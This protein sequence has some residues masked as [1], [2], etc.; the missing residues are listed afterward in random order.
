MTTITESEI[1]E[2][3]RAALSKVD[4]TPEGFFTTVELAAATGKCVRATTMKLRQLFLR[5]EVE[6]VKVTRPGIDGRNAKVPAYRLVKRAVLPDRA[7]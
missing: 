1:L 5:G 7:A 4:D 6:S 2:E 3:L